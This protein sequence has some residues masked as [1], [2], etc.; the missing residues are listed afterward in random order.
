M[1]WF[2]GLYLEDYFMY[3]AVTLAGGIREPLLTCSSSFRYS[4]TDAGCELAHK[5][6]AVKDDNREDDVPF[7]I[8]DPP[9]QAR[10]SPPGLLQLPSNA[11]YSPPRMC[12]SPTAVK[13]SPPRLTR[14]PDFDDDGETNLGSGLMTD[15][16]PR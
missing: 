4:I 2:S 3:K 9:P 7:R 15:T 10:A 6:E 16:A 5:L 13:D 14:L 12:Q 8:I 1:S 11:G